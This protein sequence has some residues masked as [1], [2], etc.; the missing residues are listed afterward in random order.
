MNFDV[1]II[2][3]LVLIILFNI[4]MPLIGTCL[5]KRMYRNIT[6]EKVYSDISEVLLREIAYKKGEVY[7]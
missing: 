1:S 2:P 7:E 4:L 5:D 6:K 3:V